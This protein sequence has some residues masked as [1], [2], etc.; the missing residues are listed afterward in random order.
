MI[1]FKYWIGGVVLEPDRGKW[2]ASAGWRR[3]TAD[4]IMEGEV[5]TRYACEHQAEAIDALVATLGDL[6]ISLLTPGMP[7]TAL[8][9]E[10][11]GVD[12]DVDYPE[13]WQEVLDAEAK[14]R[15]WWTS[16]YDPRPDAKVDA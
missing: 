4:Q 5:R 10:G 9:I 13:G 2:R 1:D 15:G 14:R 3:V 12:P 8:F 16:S 11:D 6:G 7:Y